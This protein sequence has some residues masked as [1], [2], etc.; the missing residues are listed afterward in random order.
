M[1]VSGDTAARHRAPTRAPLSFRQLTNSGQRH[2]PGNG[3]FGWGW[4]ILVSGWTVPGYTE[5]KTLGAG[6]FGAVVLARHD[7]TGTPVAIKFLRP[8]L[9]ADPEFAELFRAEAVLLGAVDSPYVVRLYEYVESPDGAAI[10]ME[11]VDGVSLQEIVARHGKTTPEAAL[12]VLYGSL[13]RTSAAWCI[14]TSSR[15]TCWSIPM[16]PAS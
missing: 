10:V 2:E 1:L 11:L 7:A 13:R 5:L 3:T 4:G 8:G 12:L 9:L 6:G 14:A 16:A 15:R